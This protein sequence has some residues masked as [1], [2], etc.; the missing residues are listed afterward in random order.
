MRK[1]KRQPKAHLFVCHHERPDSALPAC[2]H[3]G[4]QAVWE[5]LE[6][7]LPNLAEVWRTQTGCL[8]WCSAGGVTVFVSEGSEMHR[9][10]SVVPDDVPDLL[11]L[12]GLYDNE[13]DEEENE[14]Q[15]S[16]V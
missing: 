1:V 9:Y 7:H 10:R 15:D 13:E 6:H 11:K 2:L 12:C 16:E 8:G 3:V 5:R 14:T 4:A